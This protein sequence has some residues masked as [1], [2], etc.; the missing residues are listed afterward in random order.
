MSA[1]M[2]PSQKEYLGRHGVLKFVATMLGRVLEAKPEEPMEFMADF[3]AKHEPRKDGMPQSAADTDI[4][5]MLGNA[6][7]DPFQRLGADG[8]PRPRS[9]SSPARRISQARIAGQYLEKND[10]LG[11]VRELL[12]SVLERQPENPFK[13][14]ETC[15]RTGKPPTPEPAED[16]TPAKKE[17]TPAEKPKEAA[18]PPAP[19]IDLSDVMAKLQLSLT[20][21]IQNGS[22]QEAIAS[23][24][25]R[26]G[27]Y[28]VHGGGGAPG[29]KGGAAKG[30]GKGTPTPKAAPK[31]SV[32]PPPKTAAAADAE[33]QI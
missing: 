23:L 27:G 8:Q 18:K 10:V 16:E 31:S 13:F 24:P 15:L 17:E 26:P 29:A 6:L 7:M 28:A 2:E 12:S 20:Q 9:P 3:L 4:D 1:A 5:A 14:M 19:K 32:T 25:T 21:S 33:Q 22:L 30:V 11:K